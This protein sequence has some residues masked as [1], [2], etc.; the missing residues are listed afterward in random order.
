LNGTL[1]WESEES[2]GP[3]THIYFYQ[4]PRFVRIPAMKNYEPEEV[5]KRRI[6]PRKLEIVYFPTE[7][8]NAV[9]TVAND[10]KQFFIAGVKIFSDYD[11]INGR[12]VKIEKVSEGMLYSS[13]FDVVWETPKS[14]LV[15]GEDF[16]V[17]DFNGDGILD[18]A[19]L[20]YLKKSGKSKIDIYK[21]PGM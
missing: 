12:S 19:F 17:G 9:I 8:R 2:L 3:F 14:P 5:A 6:M 1:V 15:Y 16:A 7:Q 10:K 13:Y 20:G 11:G 18:L 4:T 21:L